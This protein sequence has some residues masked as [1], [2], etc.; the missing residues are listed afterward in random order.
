MG[1]LEGI[2]VVEFAG[3]G[4]AP[5]CGMILADMGAE[6]FLIDRKS[7]KSAEASMH[8]KDRDML[9]RGKYQLAADLKQSKDLTFV[10]DLIAKCNV[11]LESFRPGVMERLGLGP[12]ICLEKN[13][14]LVFARMS[15]WGQDGPLAMAAG[16]DPNYVAL[17]GALYHTGGADGVPQSPATLLGDAAGGAGMTAMGICAALIPAIQKGTGQVIDAAIGEG[18][19]YLT[20]LARS[21]YYVGQMTNDR[22]NSWMEGAAPWGRAYR[23]SDDKFI[24]LLPVE[25]RFYKTFLELM[26]L[27]QGPHFSV[28]HQYDASQWPAQIAKLDSVFATRSRQQWCDLLEGT[29]ACF[30]PVLSYDEAPQHPHNQARNNFVQAGE[31]WYPVPAPKFG[32][33]QPEP[34]WDCDATANAREALDRLGFDDCAVNTVVD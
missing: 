13:P 7:E 10:L 4:A 2:K 26:N 18:T 23:C 16:H 22:G 14:S 27:N 24:T 15:G 19:S 8:I 32:V 28:S 17:T 6:V 3:L 29:D 31:D 20:T 33:T 34:D 11:V 9:N 25:G 30:A 5:M 21:L 1:P 12:D